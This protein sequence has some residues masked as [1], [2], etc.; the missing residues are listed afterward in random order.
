MLAAMCK[1]QTLFIMPRKSI[2][3]NNKDN[4]RNNK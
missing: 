1:M 4:F 2:K 3:S